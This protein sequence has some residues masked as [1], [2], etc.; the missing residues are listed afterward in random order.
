MGCVCSYA[1]CYVSVGLCCLCTCVFV[2]VAS[3]HIV[4]YHTISYHTYH[5][6]SYCVI[7]LYSMVSHPIL[8]YPKHIQYILY[9][10]V[11]VVPLCM[12]QEMWSLCRSEIHN[13][14][15]VFPHSCSTHANPGLVRLLLT[16]QKKK[17][18][19]IPWTKSNAVDAGLIWP[20]ALLGEFHNKV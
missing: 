17:S 13:L 11:C 9:V 18:K 6:A 19:S 12:G 15:E 5:F 2:H 8:S 16:E 10:W 4:L 7:P 20:K 14:R 1:V 3:C